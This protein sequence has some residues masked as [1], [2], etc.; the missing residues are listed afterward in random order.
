MRINPG[1]FRG[2]MKTLTRNFVYSLIACLCFVT[3]GAIDAQVMITS[4]TPPN[5]TVGMPYS[6]LFTAAGG[7]ASPSSPLAQPSIAP[8][9]TINGAP[10]PILFAGLTPGLVGL[11]QMNLQVPAGLTTGDITI[12]VSQNGQVS[13]QTVLP[14]QP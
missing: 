10:S 5:G 1:L 7:A 11:Y 12:V 4:G 3:G 14:Y 13:N 6:F 8:T 2:I 9:L